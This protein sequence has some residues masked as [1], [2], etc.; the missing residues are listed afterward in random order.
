MLNIPLV[1]IVHLSSLIIAI[2]ESL[3]ADGTLESVVDVLMSP[4]HLLHPRL[5]MTYI[6]PQCM[7]CT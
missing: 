7:L 5:Q 4:V 6:T 2:S 1:F 3:R